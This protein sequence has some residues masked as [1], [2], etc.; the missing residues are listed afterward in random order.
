M[1][2]YSFFIAD[3][4]ESGH[5]FGDKYYV[6]DSKFFTHDISFIGVKKR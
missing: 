1:P 2:K 4:R 3:S 5:L 6:F